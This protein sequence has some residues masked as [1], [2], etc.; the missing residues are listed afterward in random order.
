MVG[1]YNDN[2]RNFLLEN[3]II[4]FQSVCRRSLSN[5]PLDFTL[6]EHFTFF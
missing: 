2:S 5:R 3:A 4:I 1:L 6:M